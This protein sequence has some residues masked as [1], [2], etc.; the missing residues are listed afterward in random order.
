MIKCRISKIEPG[1]I[2]YTQG[3]EWTVEPLV[4]PGNKKSTFFY[5][6]DATL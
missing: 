1:N 2:I 6:R 5:L 4:C 3:N